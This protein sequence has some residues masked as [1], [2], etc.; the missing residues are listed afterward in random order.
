[1]YA[2]NHSLVKSLTEKNNIK[3]YGWDDKKKAIS[4]LK[5]RLHKTDSKPRETNDVIDIILNS[6]SPLFKPCRGFIQKRLRRCRPYVAN[7][8][9]WLIEKEIVLSQRTNL[10]GKG[11]S[12]VYTINYSKFLKNSENLYHNP[13]KKLFLLKK[14]KEIP[15]KNLPKS[16]LSKSFTPNINNIININIPS[17]KIEAPEIVVKELIEISKY[18]ISP[19]LLR[20]SL[21]CKKESIILNAVL[22]MNQAPGPIKNPS[23]Y[24]FRLIEREAA[25]KPIGG[26]LMSQMSQTP[27]DPK[28][29]A[30]EIQEQN[31]RKQMEADRLKATIAE[32]VDNEARGIFTEGRLIYLTDATVANL[33]KAH[34]VKQSQSENKHHKRFG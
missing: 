16:S 9:K 6:E 7:I 28:Q 25:P 30:K 12:I 14:P 23:H 21:A 34:P 15:Q 29:H 26:K 18:P 3:N 11:S 13:G 31:L 10:K 2:I 19:H 1:M 27:I 20:S 17:T 33:K 5:R 22:A 4:L 24:L 32:M 8:L